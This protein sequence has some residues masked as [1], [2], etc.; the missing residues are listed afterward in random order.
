V[1][2]LAISGP[3]TISL[4]AHSL[5]TGGGIE[6]PTLVAENLKIFSS[7]SSAKGGL[8]IAGGPLVYMAVYAPNAKIVARGGD[9]YGSVVGG[10]VET[11]AQTKFHYDKRLK[12]NQ[13]GGITM[14][15]WR[16]V[17]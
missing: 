5:L 8:D 17:F 7:V 14:V 11:A 9:L 2:A 13:D 4:T 12:D 3:V 1:S 16:E 15:T 10:F 6:N